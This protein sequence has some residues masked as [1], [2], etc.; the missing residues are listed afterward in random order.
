[1]DK[2]WL[3]EIAHTYREANKCADALTNIGCYLDYDI[4]FF[5]F[6]PISNQW[7]LWKGSSGE[8]HPETCSWSSG[9]R[10][11]SLSKKK[12]A[13]IFARLVGTPHI[14]SEI[15]VRTTDTLHV[16]FWSEISIH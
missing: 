12:I 13:S 2:D 15:E 1:L 6:L 16:H 11:S 5:L 4:I 9:F 7:D 3:V 8:Y 14:L 10:P